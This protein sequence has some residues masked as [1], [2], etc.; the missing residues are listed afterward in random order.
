MAEDRDP[1]MPNSTS[2]ACPRGI[3]GLGAVLGLL[4]LSNPV[5]FFILVIA[6]GQGAAFCNGYWQLDPAAQLAGQAPPA[7]DGA[8]RPLPPA[9]CAQRRPGT[10]SARPSLRNTFLSCC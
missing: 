5:P 4:F 2:D 6:K 8:P 1:A 9:A 3:A 7:P 10:W